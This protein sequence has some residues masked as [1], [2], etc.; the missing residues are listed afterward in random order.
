MARFALLAGESGSFVTETMR[1]FNE[2]EAD[3]LLKDL[4]DP[5]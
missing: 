4:P 2:A 3:A 5:G 1:V